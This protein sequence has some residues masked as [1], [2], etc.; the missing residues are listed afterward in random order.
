MEYPRLLQ[1]ACPAR[2]RSRLANFLGAGPTVLSTIAVWLAVAGP[3]E[4]VAYAS[5]QSQ[6]TD[7]AAT[8]DKTATTARGQPDRSSQSSPDKKPSRKGFAFGISAGPRQISALGIDNVGGPGATFALRFG[9]TAGENLLWIFQFENTTDPQS[10][11]VG[12]N[13]TLNN[14]TSL[15]LGVQYYVQEFFW[16]RG[17]AGVAG[18]LIPA[19]NGKESKEKGG[20]AFSAAG[21][22]DI[23]TRGIF[24]LSLE[25]GLIANLYSGEGIVVGLG[26]GA[27]TNW[28]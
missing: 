20:V 5:P 6:P 7:K 12:G 8:T 11:S 15:T 27:A 22:Y 16:V 24:A 26:F 9:T 28:Y 23:F 1:F 25:L 10:N 3:A 2:R 13:P 18:L 4:L 21:G 17:G 14:Y 19:S